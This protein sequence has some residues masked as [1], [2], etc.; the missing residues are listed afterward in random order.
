MRRSFLTLL[1]AAWVAGCSPVRC[2]TCRGQSGSAGTVVQRHGHEFRSDPNCSHGWHVY[3]AGTQVG[4]YRDDT[5]AYWPLDPKTRTFGPPRALPWVEEAKPAAAKPVNYGVDTDKLGSGVREAYRLNG[6]DVDRG[7]ALRSI[8]GKELPDDRNRPRLTIIGSDAERQRVRNDLASAPELAAYRDRFVVQDYPPEHWA[9]AG[10]GFKTDGH[11]TIYLQAP[12]G[13]V[14]HRQDDY[15]DGAAGL[16]Q[17][18]RRAQP[19]YH[20]TSDP[21]LRAA[22]RLP[23]AAPPLP[24]LASAAG[25]IFLLL[26]PR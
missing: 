15:R 11:P 20:P 22:F 7:T 1:L 4:Y 23:V 25:L 13:R 12:S 5:S 19:D 24:V 26:L 14:L 2:P 10:V 16:A 8:Q 9:V 6:R 18:L 17:A 21:D 3:R